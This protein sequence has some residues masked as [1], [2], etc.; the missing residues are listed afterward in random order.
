MGSSLS[1]FYRFANRSKAC[2]A[3]SLCHSWVEWVR[4][5]ICRFETALQTHCPG[6]CLP[7]IDTRLDC[8]LPVPGATALFTGNFLGDPWGRVR[9]GIAPNWRPEPADCDLYG[10]NALMRFVDGGSCFRGLLYTHT[11]VRNLR[12]LRSFDQYVRPYDLSTA[13]R[14]HA[15]THL[16]VDGHMASLS[17]APNDPCFWLHHCCVDC[18][19]E[20]VKDRVGRTAWTQYPNSWWV[21]ARHRRRDPMLP[22]NNYVNEDALFDERIDKEYT[23]EISPADDPCQTDAECSPVGLLWCDNRQC[24]AKARQGGSC[25]VGQH[26]MCYCDSGTPLC[27]GTCQCQWWLI[28]SDV[29][30]IY[31]Q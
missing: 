21:P 23:Y 5:C 10:N 14:E 19:G 20:M 6:C 27:T 29:I 1:N 30:I 8:E 24:K 15:G 9:S 12:G 3:R 11:M 28:V 13:E 2:I 31:D 7:Y 17:C 18:L 25:N 16:F 4:L 26:A 22:F